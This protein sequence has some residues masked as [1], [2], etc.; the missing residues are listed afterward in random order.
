MSVNLPKSDWELTAIER[1]LNEQ[2]RLGISDGQ[3][4]EILGLNIYFY[5]LIA[6]EKPELK[7]YEMSVD[8]QA[9]LDNAGFDLFYLMTGEYC[10][11]NYKL[12]LEAFD[13]AIAELPN[14]ERDNV[15][16]LTEPVYE[17]LLKAANS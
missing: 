14:A 9:A 10:S 15:H 1:L 16:R 2:K 7:V 12:M 3:M 5:Y 11:D 8:V 6:D 13:Y 4:A 17:Q